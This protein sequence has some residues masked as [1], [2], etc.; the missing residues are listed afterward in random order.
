MTDDWYRMM[1]R[2]NPPESLLDSEV[3]GGQVK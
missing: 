3:N 2:A 1:T